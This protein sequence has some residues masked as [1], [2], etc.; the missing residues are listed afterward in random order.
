MKMFVAECVN[1]CD[2]Y[3]CNF[4]IFWKQKSQRRCYLYHHCDMISSDVQFENL[5]IKS[6]KSTTNH[7]SKYSIQNKNG[8]LVIDV[9]VDF[10]F[11]I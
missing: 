3:G 4:F 2:Y 10:P 1:N 8:N 11:K 7:A 6:T 9:D 5:Y